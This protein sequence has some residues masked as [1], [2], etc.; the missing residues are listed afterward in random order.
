[1]TA[2]STVSL[3]EVLKVQNGFAFKSELFS[4]T[5]GV[6]LIRI[7]DLPNSS[8]ETRFRGEYRPEFLIAPGDFLIGMDGEFR[9][10][11][12]RGPKGLLNQRVCRLHEFSPHVEPE[13]VF[14]AI[15]R[16]LAEIEASTS[17]VTVKHLSSKQIAAIE[18]PLPPIPEQR[19][20]VDVLNRANGIRRLRRE[21]QE[22]VREVIP[23][24]FAE[25]FGD[26]EENSNR[27]ATSQFGQLVA[28]TQLG[29]VRGARE[30][31]ANYPHLYLRMDSIRGDGSLDLSNLRRVEASTEEIQRHSLRRGDFLF[32]T[33]NSR[34]LVG[35]VGLYTEDQPILFNNNILRVRFDRAIDP[36]YMVHYFQTSAAQ[37]E[38]EKRKSG[39]TSVFAVYYKSL[40][41]LPV[42]VPPLTLQEAFASRVADLQSII[43]QQE[44]AAVACEQLVNSLMGRM[45]AAA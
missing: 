38:L 12:W 28:D 9:C 41:T 16:R 37:R 7:R 3:G 26:L 34:E 13:Y 25:M 22:K 39:T 27:W 35:K 18:I 33:R 29:L 45:F 2:W 40:A 44:R 21:A 23:A 31:D 36:M 20:I 19:R 5:E 8:T 6:P 10:F 11:K 24:L 42:V 32:N 1:M 30:M 15:S 4:E 17:Y 14:Y 43:T